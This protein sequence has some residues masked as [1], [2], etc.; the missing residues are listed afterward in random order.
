MKIVN[1]W[2]PN[3]WG[4]SFAILVI[5]CTIDFW[6]FSILNF[7]FEFPRTEQAR[8]IHRCEVKP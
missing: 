5:F 3:A 6:G 7:L 4:W 8:E 2:R 1:Q